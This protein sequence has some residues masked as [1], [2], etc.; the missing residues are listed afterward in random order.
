MTLSQH[1]V[2]SARSVVDNVAEN[3]VKSS[4]FYV[5]DLSHRLCF[6]FRLRSGTSK[7]K[8]C[9]RQCLQTCRK[10]SP[11]NQLLSVT[12]SGIF[13][14]LYSCSSQGQK[15]VFDF[16]AKNKFGME[17]SND[18]TRI[19]RKYQAHPELWDTKHTWYK[20]RNRKYDA[21][22]DIATSLEMEVYF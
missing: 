21:W 5:A 16:V 20:N 10:T 9:R 11:P 15:F 2:V 14:H 7:E 18:K 8:S 3:S 1:I 17:W 6:M 12:L 22:N 13:C 19:L 4:T